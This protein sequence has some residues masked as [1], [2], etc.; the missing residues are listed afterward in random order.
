MFRTLCNNPLQA[1]STLVLGLFLLLTMM[2]LARLASPV[3][4]SANPTQQTGMQA[5]D[6]SGG[7]GLRAKL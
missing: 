6:S 7:L 4:E 3:L 2:Y 1:L 5:T